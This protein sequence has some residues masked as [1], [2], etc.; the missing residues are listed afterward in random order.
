VPF[1]RAR[2]RRF[3]D[4]YRAFGGSASVGV[5]DRPRAD[6]LV[7]RGFASRDDREVQHNAPMTVP[8]GE[9]TY[10][11]GTEGGT[12][13]Y[14]S[15]SGSALAS[16]RFSP[17]ALRPRER[18]LR[19]GLPRHARGLVH[20]VSAQAPAQLPGRTW[21]A[22]S[23][24]TIADCAAAPPLFYADW[25]HRI[26]DAFPLLRAYRERLLRRPSFARA[27]EEARPYRPNFSL[28]APNRD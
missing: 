22:G 9:V 6:R 10:G 24:F 21:A 2:V 15:A 4:G 27:V 1:L 12:L 13:S 14:A 7:L 16:T 3:H 17:V 5:L 19:S 18:A 11:K 25:T 23:E 8:Y 26:S 28:G 20:V